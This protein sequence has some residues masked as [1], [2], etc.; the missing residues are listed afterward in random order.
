MTE[1]KRLK[2]GTWRTMSLDEKK[3][4]KRELGKIYREKNHEKIQEYQKNYW[5]KRKQVMPCR[6]TCAKCGIPFDAPRP[7]YKVCPNCHFL[8]TKK[9]MA[10]K[11]KRVKTRE[12]RHQKHQ[13][14]IDMY[15]KQNMKYDE[16]AKALNISYS[17]VQTFLRR[18]AML[19]KK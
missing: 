15:Y 16:I 13:A 3:E 8:I 6:A 14:I 11:E 2:W 4:H 12:A 1:T 17:S 9:V 7:T 18:Y 10:D 19:L 5:Q